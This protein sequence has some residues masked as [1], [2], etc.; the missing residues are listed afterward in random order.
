MDRHDTAQHEAHEHQMA[1]SDGEMHADHGGHDMQG[2]K[3][4]K[5]I[6]RNLIRQF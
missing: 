5:D 6:I 2:M 3:H 4:V 1:H